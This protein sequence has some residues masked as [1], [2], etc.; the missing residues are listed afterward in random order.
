M[1]KDTT[2]SLGSRSSATSTPASRDLG[3]IRTAA[4][5]QRSVEW[6][7]LHLDIMRCLIVVKPE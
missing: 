2:V 6:R 4:D 7:N 3:G 5:Q 1:I